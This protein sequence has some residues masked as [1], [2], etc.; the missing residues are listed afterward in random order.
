MRRGPN[1]RRDQRDRR[2]DRRALTQARTPGAI[3][4][5]GDPA[6]AARLAKALD[7]GDEGPREGVHAF[8]SYPA[9]M[10]PLTARRAIALLKLR[11][12]A[13]VLDPFCGSGTVLVEAV[14]AGC[15]AIG[16][17]ASPLATL[18][19]RAKLWPAT[20]RRRGELAARVQEIHE[21]AIAEGKAARRSGYI[22]P[23]T[24]PPDKARDERLKGWFAPHVRRELEFLASLVA[25]EPDVELREL[26]TA[27][28]S[29]VIVKVSR[30]VSDTRAEKVERTVARGMAARLFL[31]RGRELLAGQVELQRLAPPNTPAADVRIGDARSL[32]FTP[33]TI[34]A[35][36]TSPPYAGTYDYLDQ[37]ALRLDFMGLPVTHLQAVEIG[38]RR[39]F[40]SRIDAAL[41]KWERDLQQCLAQMVRVLVPGGAAVLLIGDSFAGRPPAAR[42]V[43]ADETVA[44][45]APPAGLTVLA[46]ASAPRAPLGAAEAAAFRARPKREH[47]ILLRRA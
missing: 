43:H 17:D 19:A 35:V 16:V 21:R 13:T 39:S 34:D 29:S 33:G 11:P 45:G 26:M 9:R 42:A 36:V 20:T 1:D 30:R 14:L 12:G 18:I 7:V 23:G 6:L 44:R 10:H 2:G 32:P 40:T 27:L 28:L 31:D 25:A 41:L 38:S 22:P 46:R 15:R 4:T 8:H 3:E 37:H 5:D 47:L 24:T